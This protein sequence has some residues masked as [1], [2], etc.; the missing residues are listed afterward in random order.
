MR[1]LFAILFVCAAVLHFIA[2]FANV[3][4]AVVKAGTARNE[5]AYDEAT[6]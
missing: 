1:R 2:E 3:G 6:R 5:R 4:S